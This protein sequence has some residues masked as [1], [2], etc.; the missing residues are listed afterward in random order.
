MLPAYTI[1]GC[2]NAVDHGCDCPSTV[3]VMVVLISTPCCI[4]CVQRFGVICC[5]RVQSD[6]ICFR[7]MLKLCDT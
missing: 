5:L 7:W 1:T 6:R 2:H 4:M 3:H